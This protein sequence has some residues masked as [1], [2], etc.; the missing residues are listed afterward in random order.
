MSATVGSLIIFLAG[1]GA[2]REI[3]AA[4]NRAIVMPET[5]RSNPYITAC[6]GIRV[7]SSRGARGGSGKADTR[8]IVF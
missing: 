7:N 1:I 5:R 4:E 2:L 6:A 8:D 3:A